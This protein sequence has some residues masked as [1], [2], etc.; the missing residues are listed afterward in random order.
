MQCD[1]DSHKKL[2]DTAEYLHFDSF[3]THAD[4]DEPILTDFEQYQFYIPQR[5]HEFLT[6]GYG[7]YMTIPPEDKR[8]VHDFDAEWV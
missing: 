6:D 7:D 1:Y 8:E 5:Y 4:F 2:L 3:F